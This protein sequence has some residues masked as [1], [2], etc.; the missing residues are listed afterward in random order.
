VDHQL[1]DLDGEAIFRR[2]EH[3][4]LRLALDQIRGMDSEGE[5]PLEPVPEQQEDDGGTRID[6]LI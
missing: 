5:K 3:N 2:K 4:N 1:T 6:S